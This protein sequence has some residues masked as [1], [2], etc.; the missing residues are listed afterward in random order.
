MKW[1]LNALTPYEIAGLRMISAGIVL[2]PFFPQAW[3]H[4][5]P[6][7]RL[8][9]ILI[10]M[11][12]SFIP[13]IFFC[14][15]E[16]SLNS[17]VAAILNATTPLF[18]VLVGL[19]FFHRSAGVMQISG[20]VVGFLGVLLLF[21]PSLSEE[22]HVF[23]SKSLLVLMATIMYGFNV[24]IANCHLLQTKPLHIAALSF[25]LLIPLDLSLLVQ[26]GFPARD[27]YS[28]HVQKAVLASVVLGVFGT[29]TATWLFY[30]LMKKAGP[31][32][33]AMVT[34]GIPFVAIGW[35]LLDGEEVGYLSLL[36]LLLIL[37]GVYLANK[38][39]SP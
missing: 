22:N 11:L 6:K 32:F 23:S 21:Y 39:K 34:Y 27:F 18:V 7:V 30:V 38:K 37:A 31:L 15:A 13:A 1:G 28:I 9:T 36:A 4:S 19:I 29:A 3:R 26:Q 10:G 2:L 20:V 5:T 8:F 16:T 35:G 24:N 12:G 17:S 14:I 33:S 25:V